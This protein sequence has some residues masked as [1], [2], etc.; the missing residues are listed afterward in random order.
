MNN[1]MNKK[2]AVVA[3][4]SRRAMRLDPLVALRYE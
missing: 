2:K 1:Q 3:F 4:A